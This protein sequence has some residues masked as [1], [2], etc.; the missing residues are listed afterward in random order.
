MI[1][2]MAAPAVSRE[3][4]L[5][6]ETGQ[7]SVAYSTQSGGS[8]RGN[9]ERAGLGLGCVARAPALVRGPGR[10]AA[11]VFGSG[12][13]GEE[14][15]AVGADAAREAHRADRAPAGVVVASAVIRSPPG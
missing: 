6:A 5:R 10:G 15:G 2:R 9:G 3:R 12:A 13:G 8:G 1:M 14:T 11:Q 7:H 4:S